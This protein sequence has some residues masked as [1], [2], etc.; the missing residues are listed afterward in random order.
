M[1]KKW[2]L[3]FCVAAVPNPHTF[4]YS[5]L[6]SNLLIIFFF[7]FPW[8]PLLGL[9]FAT[10]TSSFYPAKQPSPFERALNNSGTFIHP[11]NVFFRET[12][13]TLVFFWNLT[14]FCR[15]KSPTLDFTIPKASLMISRRTELA[16]TF[17]CVSSW[18]KHLADDKNRLFSRRLFFISVAKLLFLWFRPW[19][20][21]HITTKGS[22]PKDVSYEKEL[23]KKNFID[24]IV[25]YHAWEAKGQH[26]D[27]LWYCH[28]CFSPE[29]NIAKVLMVWRRQKIFVEITLSW[30]WQKN[31]K[32][33]ILSMVKHHII[34]QRFPLKDSV[35]F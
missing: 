13:G 4:N 28:C 24:R 33:L 3:C 32:F 15:F 31:K 35:A 27:E 26:K 8:S 19:A 11:A 17:F 20:F 18:S 10:P 21:F 30:Q 29:K 9:Q 14:L 12:S 7:G 6:L 1:P 16:V 34:A 22:L 25:Y 2:L 5:D 23:L